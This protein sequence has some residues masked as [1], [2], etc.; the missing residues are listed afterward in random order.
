MNLNCWIMLAKAQLI[1]RIMIFKRKKTYPEIVAE[2]QTQAKEMNLQI[3][4]YQQGRTYNW[5]DSRDYYTIL[6]KSDEPI[7]RLLIC[8]PNGIVVQ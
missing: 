7:I 1:W 4:V 6:I 3:T 8:L 5:C 2:A